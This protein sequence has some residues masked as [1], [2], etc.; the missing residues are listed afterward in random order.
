MEY[1][2]YVPKEHYFIDLKKSRLRK[3]GKDITIIE[4]DHQY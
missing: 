3:K 2:E 1:K 4:L